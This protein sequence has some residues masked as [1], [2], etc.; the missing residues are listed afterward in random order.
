MKKYKVSFQIDGNHTSYK[1]VLA[2]DEETASRRVLLDII[3]HIDFDQPKGKISIEITNVKEI[4]NGKT[5][6]P[7][8]E[9]DN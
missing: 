2:F 7:T 6:R 9:A 1:E 5:E 3:T 8:R 4:P